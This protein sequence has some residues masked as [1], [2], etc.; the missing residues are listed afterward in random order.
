MEI[1]VGLGNPGKKYENT[2]HNVGFMVLDHLARQQGLN[3]KE[4]KKINAWTCEY[5]D[6]LLAKP[7]T[8]MNNSG[9][10]VQPLLSYYQLIPK[11]WKILP[12]QGVDLTDTL[13]VI[14]DDIDLPLGKYRVSG[15]S[16]SG[17]HKGIRSIMDHIKT[18]KFT[19]IRVGIYTP[20][21]EKIPTPQFVLQR[22]SREEKGTMEKLIPEIV[23]EYLE[24]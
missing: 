16:R 12:K 21:K 9:L 7:W 18:Q 14:H 3:W 17:G 2:K 22:L 5:E 20:M 15:N 8:L 11:K 4:N 6:K 19:R 13:T 23:E 10:A 24:T 1:I